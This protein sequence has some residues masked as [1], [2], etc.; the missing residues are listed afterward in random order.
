MSES[1]LAISSCTP[2]WQENLIK[3]YEDDELAKQLLAEL[4]LSTENSKGYSLVNVIIRYKGPVWIGQNTL[5]QQHVNNALHNS[6]LGVHSGFLATYHM[7]KS[8]FAWPKMKQDCLCRSVQ[9]ANRPKWSIL[10]C[11]D[12]WNHSLFLLLPGL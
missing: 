12:C 8:L 5:A 3:G 2:A 11:L 4:A 1:L 7:I 9:Y 10:N 6:G